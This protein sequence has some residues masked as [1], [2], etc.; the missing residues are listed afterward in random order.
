ME[1]GVTLG[2]IRLSYSGKVLYTG[3]SEPGA[4]GSVRCYKFGPF[5]GEYIEYQAHS[6]PLE[7]LRVSYDDTHIFTVGQDG[8]ICIFEVKDRDLRRRER[9]LIG[10]TLSEEVIVTKGDIDDYNMQIETLN[11][12]M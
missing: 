10:I 8:C 9:E 2:Q 4:P 11:S 3:V 5:T 1:I 7:R 12:Q 6:A